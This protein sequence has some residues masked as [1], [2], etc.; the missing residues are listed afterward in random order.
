MAHHAWHRVLFRGGKTHLVPGCLCD[1]TI[2]DLASRG[3]PVEDGGPLE[4]IV[5]VREWSLDLGG[6]IYMTE[7]SVAVKVDNLTVDM[8]CSHVGG[9]LDRL[10]NCGERRFASG[11]RYYKWHGKWH[12]A[13]FT[14]RQ[15]RALTVAVEEVAADS[16][17]RW[18]AFDARLPIA[19]N[20]IA[21]KAV[22]R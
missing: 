6:G 8:L 14:P 4:P 19:S 13:V 9:V 2:A 1:D 12:C 17:A 5:R 10:R 11:A 18:E 16:A 21:V 20:V 3:I 7:P 15:H 22:L